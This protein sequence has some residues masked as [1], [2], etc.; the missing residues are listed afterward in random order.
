MEGK[1]AQVKKPAR[2]MGAWGNSLKKDKV[3]I[4][5]KALNLEIRVSVRKWA[6]KSMFS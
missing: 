4:L 5:L 6:V 1:E 3:R 2:Q